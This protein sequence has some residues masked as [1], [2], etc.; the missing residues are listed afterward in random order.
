MAT[1][2]VPLEVQKGLQI[3][4]LPVKVLKLV[5][6]HSETAVYSVK[7]KSWK[8]INVE[9]PPKM[10][11]CFS[12]SVFL[13]GFIHW[14]AYTDQGWKRTILLFDVC[15][16]VLGEAQLPEM[17]KCYDSNPSSISVVKGSLCLLVE[18]LRDDEGICHVWTMNEYGVSE[19]WTKQLRVV[20][21]KISMSSLKLSWWQNRIL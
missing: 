21:G 7:T 15:N 3:M 9:F 20:H 13:R 16:E 19:S 11:W 2:G 17:D 8:I 6:G 1:P 12:L 14:L 10:L 4:L 18:E 5:Y